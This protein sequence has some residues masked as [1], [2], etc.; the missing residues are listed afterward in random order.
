MSLYPEN[1][2]IVRRKVVNAFDNTPAL[3]RKDSWGEMYGETSSETLINQ[4]HSFVGR[5]KR[6]KGWKEGVRQSIKYMHTVHG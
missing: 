6:K 5:G 2:V 3:K 4:L 1:M